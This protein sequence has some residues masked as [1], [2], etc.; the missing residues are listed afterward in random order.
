M[1]TRVGE[2]LRRVVSG[3]WIVS[4]GPFFFEIWTWVEMDGYGGIR[5]SY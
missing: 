1:R 4:H 5:D 3:I 2:E